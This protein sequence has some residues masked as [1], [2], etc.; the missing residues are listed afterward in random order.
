[1]AARQQ[2]RQVGSAR[3]SHL[4]FTGGIGGIVDL[5]NFAALVGGLDDWEPFYRN[6]DVRIVHEKR[7][8]ELTR[9]RLSQS[10]RE[11]RL[12]PLSDDDDRALVGVPVRAFP[13]WLRCTRCNLL[14]PVWGEAFTYVNYKRTRPDLAVFQHQN[15]G[16]RR[17]LDAKAVP[18]RFVVVCD[19]GHLDE[20]PYEPFVH[21]GSACPKAEYPILEMVDRA[22]NR[23]VDVRITCKSCNAA[24]N[25]KDAMGDTGRGEL[26]NCRGR[27]PHLH[28]F[29]ECRAPL[30]T[31]VVGA[32]NLWF[33]QT[34]SV[35]SVPP[36]DEDRLRGLVAEHEEVLRETVWSVDA[37]T[38][39][40]LMR[41][42]P[43]LKP[44]LDFEP[45]QLRAA[46]DAH[47]PASDQREAGDLQAP[48]W[49][50]FTAEKLPA[51]EYFTAVR[52][53][54]GVPDPLKPYFTDVVQAERLREVRAFHGFTRLDAPDPE[55]PDLVP[56]ARISRGEPTW[57]PASEVFGEGIFLRLNSD[58]LRTWEARVADEEAV[59]RLQAAWRNFRG[60]RR[61]RRRGGEFDPMAGWPGIGYVVLHTLSHLLI[62]AIAL[63]CGYNSASLSER[64]YYDGNDRAGLLI[65]TAVPDAEGTLGGLVSLAEAGSLTRIVG[66]ALTEAGRCSSDPVCADHLPADPAD[67]LHGAACHAC[68]FVSETTC[69]R[70]NRFLDRRFVTDLGDGLSFLEPWR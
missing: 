6:S 69:E 15:C 39:A 54:E 56:V 48:E 36:D 16:G 38:L 67:S 57:A 29:G 4:M 51:N 40:G 14:A 62:R 12:I 49:K 47:V 42:M 45:E 21:R 5:P 33:P 41:H 44:F 1:M 27:H 25:L 68:L 13:S 66:R 7:L 50:A 31:I 26:P 61:S 17:G 46:M 3:P 63:E 23:Q 37:K 52:D 53:S 34:V 19:D 58:A 11:L 55:D 8:L 10:V 2:F 28:E 59:E 18:A 9:K 60:R 35:L 20:F 43:A 70:G 32:S 22:G 24:R 65:Y 64:I 30:Q